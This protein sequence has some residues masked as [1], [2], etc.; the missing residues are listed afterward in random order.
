MIS[1]S[2]SCARRRKVATVEKMTMQGGK[3]TAG[4]FFSVGREER[5][6]WV[7][8][9]ATFWPETHPHRQLGWRMRQWQC[10]MQVWAAGGVR[11][12]KGG[13]VELMSCS[14]RRKERKKK[15]KERRGDKE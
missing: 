4:G 7:M 13:G 1:T 9:G 6:R 5:E 15:E 11:E 12:N 14:S 2:K 8:F 3:K 10:C